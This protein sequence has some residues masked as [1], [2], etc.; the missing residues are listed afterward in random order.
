MSPYK[1]HS[2]LPGPLQV[3]EVPTQTR[4]H[5]LCQACHLKVFPRG[6]NGEIILPA[7]YLGTGFEDSARN[8][9]FKS[10]RGANV[11]SRLSGKV[12]IRVCSMA[13]DW[14][15]IKV[16]D[17]R[18]ARKMVNG[19][20][21]AIPNNWHPVTCH[22][23]HFTIHNLPGVTA[24]WRAKWRQVCLLVVHRNRQ[25]LS[26]GITLETFSSAHMYSIHSLL[27]VKIHPFQM[28]TL[29]R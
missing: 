29:V 26:T 23:F 16:L 15:D 2:S 22:W 12:S 25:F 10:N 27:L 14:P 18:R 7:L 5:C 11:V 28:I 19:S 13:Q 6:R 9:F 4:P 24:I 21:S 1:C 17:W 3:Q 8:S 20:I